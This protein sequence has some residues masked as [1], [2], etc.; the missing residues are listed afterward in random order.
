MFP[1]PRGTIVNGTS[2]ILF[3]SGA[4]VSVDFDLS[5]LAQIALFGLF[6]TLIKP[7][8][9]DP[10]MRLYEERERQ[11]DGARGSARSLD[12]EAN[13][14]RAR[15][16]I[17]IEAVRRDASSERYRL[18]AETAKLEA[19]MQEDAKADA[20]RILSEGRAKVAAEVA[21]LRSELDASRPALAEQIASKLLGREVKS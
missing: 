12:A 11:T 14:L 2:L 8:L 7:I 4:D 5:F 1:G 3:A 16:E 6:I 20:A 10:L 19:T 18:R 17:E 13:E 9:I 15:Y 21:K